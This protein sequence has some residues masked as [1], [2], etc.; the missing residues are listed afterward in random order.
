VVIA[1]ARAGSGAQRID[2]AGALT[3]TA[4]LVVA[5][6]AI[7]NGNQAGWLTGRTL[8]LLAVSCVLLVIFLGIEARVRSPL[9]PLRLFRRRN[10]AVSNVIG[11]LWAGALLAWLFLPALCLQLVVC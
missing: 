11:V 9:V 10:I 6:Y 5:V 8:G 2:V 7:V 1:G 3:V 4:S